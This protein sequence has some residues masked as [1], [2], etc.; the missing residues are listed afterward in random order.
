MSDSY[1]IHVVILKAVS[2][3]T[4]LRIIKFLRDGERCVSEISPAI[5][6]AQSN[7]SRHLNLMLASGVLRRRKDGI[8]INYAIK[9]PQ[10]PAMVD[11]L[12]EMMSKEISSNS[13]WSSIRLK[14]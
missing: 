7:T 8:K 5:G 11:L 1:T 6:E 9:H 13:R 10:I 12:T 4:R 3:P 14:T 2:H